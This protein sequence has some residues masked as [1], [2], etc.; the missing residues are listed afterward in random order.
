MGDLIPAESASL[1]MVPGYVAV[2]LVAAVCLAL[3]STPRS[4]VVDAVWRALRRVGRLRSVSMIGV[5]LA[6]G[7]VAVLISTARPPVPLVQDEFSY[8]LAADTFAQGRFTNPTHPQ[9]QH[10]ETFHVFQEPTYMS[11]YPP[12]QGVLLGVGQRLTGRPLVGVWLGTVLAVAAVCWMLQGWVP[13]RW[14]LLGSLLLTAHVTTQINWGQSFWGGQT[15]LMG[16]ALIYGALPRI[17][18]GA[19]PTAALLLGIGMAILVNSRPYE[20]VVVSL[21]VV[22]ALVAWLLGRDRPPLRSVAARTVLPAGMVLAAT[23]VTM[24]YYNHQVTG[25]PLRMPYMVHEDTYGYAPLFLWGSLRPAP[26]YRHASIR[27]THSYT[28]DVFTRQRSLPLAE[29]AVVKILSVTSIATRVLSPVL[30][31][32]LL[33]LPWALRRRHMKWAG[34]AVAGNALALSIATWS[35]LSHYYA[36]CLAAVWLLI[37]QGLRHMHLITVGGRRFGRMLVVGA[38]ALQVGVFGSVAY[39]YV[40]RQLHPR[41]ESLQAFADARQRLAR[42]LSGHPGKHLVMVRHDPDRERFFSWTANRADIDSAGV[43]WAHSMSPEK[44]QSLFEYFSD[45]QVWW[46]D[47]DGQDWQ[48]KK[49][50]PSA[51]YMIEGDPRDTGRSIPGGSD[52]TY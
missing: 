2:A 32:A 52:P 36:P 41:A 34:L 14:A 17:L 3:S 29:L 49:T 8:L 50:G 45:R 48:V 51:E 23:V 33:A 6:A 42:D 19:G 18:G 24:G 5:G 16:G 21:P 10:F 11:K 31:M 37:V 4:R 25:D 22:L 39:A 46:L 13:G 26:D 28:A 43:V 44:N 20:G 12:A 35:H 15:A 38:L 1:W 27:D 30:V 47:H 7:L 9:W 40:S